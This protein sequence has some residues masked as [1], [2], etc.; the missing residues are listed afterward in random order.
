[1]LLQVLL[2]RY[3]RQDDIVVGTPYANRAQAEVQQLAGCLVNMCALR[4]DVSDDPTFQQLLRR[5]GSTT[6]R[7]FLHA[8]APFA[9]VVDALRLDRSAAYNPVYQVP[10]SR[11]HQAQLSLLRSHF[12]A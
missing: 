3:S 5:V 4:T 8:D 6:Q 2:A 10:S 7:A 11:I 1:M 12:R 9:K